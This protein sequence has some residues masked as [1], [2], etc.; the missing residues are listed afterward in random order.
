MTN[1]ASAHK[2]LKIFY[3][4]F[5]KN[6]QTRLPRLNKAHFRYTKLRKSNKPL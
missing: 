3:V 4:C 2:D 5:T 6:R 1:P